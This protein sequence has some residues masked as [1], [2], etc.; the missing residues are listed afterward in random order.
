[1]QNANLKMQNFITHLLPF[2]FGTEL[3]QHLLVNNWEN[4]WVISN[5]QVVILYLPAYLEYLGLLLLF[6]IPILLSLK[7]TK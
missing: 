5:N 7:P 2:V 6:V 1:M 3:K 4:G